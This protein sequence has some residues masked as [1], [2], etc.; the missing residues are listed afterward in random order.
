MIRIDIMSTADIQFALS[1]TD[2]ER[3]GYLA[4]DF[5]RLLYLSPHGC[6]IA[7]DNDTPVGIITTVRFGAF[8][9]LGTLIVSPDY[10]NRRIG[11][12]LMRHAISMLQ[13]DGVTTI[14]L[15]GVFPAVPLYRRLGFK[16]KYISLRMFRPA[17]D[18][19]GSP[20]EP[21]SPFEALPAFDLKHIGLDRQALLTCYI[22]EFADNFMSVGPDDTPHG[23]AFVKPREDN[24]CAIGPFIARDDIAADD[25]LTRIVKRYGSSSLWLGIPEINAQATAL[26]RRLGFLYLTPSLRMY[27]GE[28]IAYEKHVYGIISAEKS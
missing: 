24:H 14:E 1:M 17:D 6:F 25:L 22:E 12:A 2:R 18:A 9:Y 5:K 13:S 28:P 19:P 11:E 21:E 27:L 7:R 26:A 15:D 10:R 16:D 3:W 23:Y 8:A 4:A 20:P